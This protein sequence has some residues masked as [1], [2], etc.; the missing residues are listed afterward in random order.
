MIGKSHLHVLALSAGMLAT[1]ALAQS[2][3]L[4][5]TREPALLNEPLEQRGREHGRACGHRPVECEVVTDD[6][7]ASQALDDVD[8]RHA[9]A[10]GHARQRAR[11]RRASWYSRLS[12]SM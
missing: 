4:Y 12:L 3:N 8:Q 9:A 11:R 5:T 1:P 10:D 6:R 2:V 7:Q